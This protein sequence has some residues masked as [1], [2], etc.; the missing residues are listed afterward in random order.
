M[1]IYTAGIPAEYGRK[2]GGIVEVNTRKIRSRVS[3]DSSCFPEAASTLPAPLRG[4]NTP[5]GRTR[6]ASAPAA[7]MT[8]HYLNPVVP[9]NYTNSGTTGDFSAHYSATSPQKTD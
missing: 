1:G 3:T 7:T 2:M 4:S 8:G 5:G 9:Q 6:L